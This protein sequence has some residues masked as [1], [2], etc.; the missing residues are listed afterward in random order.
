MCTYSNNGHS[1]L[2]SKQVEKQMCVFVLFFLCVCFFSFLPF[3]TLFSTSSDIQWVG[4]GHPPACLTNYKYGILI[5]TWNAQ[6][7]LSFIYPAF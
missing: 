7:L 1:S 2:L 6:S 5:V 3:I 4:E